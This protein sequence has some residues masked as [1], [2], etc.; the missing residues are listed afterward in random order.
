MD[1]CKKI[2]LKGKVVKWSNKSIEEEKRLFWWK[3]WDIQILRND[4]NGLKYKYTWKY[5]EGF[6][7][8]G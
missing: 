8:R 3:I 5:I 4:I 7:R 2:I 6:A 1:Y